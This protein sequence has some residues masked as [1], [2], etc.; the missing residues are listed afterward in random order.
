MK[1]FF[2]MKNK[3]ENLIEMKM[4]Y[5]NKLQK[6]KLKRVSSWKSNNKKGDKLYLK[7]KGCDN[8]FKLDW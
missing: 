1:I 2:K 5:E 8:C 4:F 3:I 7:R 6:S